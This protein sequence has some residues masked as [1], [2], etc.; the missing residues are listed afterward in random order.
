MSNT[1]TYEFNVG[2]MPNQC[3]DGVHR[4]KHAEYLKT[5]DLL[6]FVRDEENFRLFMGLKVYAF[7]PAFLH[8][9]EPLQE[10]MDKL[11]RQQRQNPLRF[12]A[13]N[14]NEQLE[15]INDDDFSAA[16]MVDPNRVGKTTAAYI[17]A[18]VGRDPLIKADPSWEIFRDH[19]VEYHRFRRPCSMGICSYNIAKLEDPIWSDVI[20]KWTPDSELGKYG[21]TYDG[22]GGK[23]SPSFKD[24]K[25]LIFE[26]SK[27]QIGFYTYEMDQ[28]NYEGAALKKWLWDEQGEEAKFDGADRGTRTTRGF[29]LFSLTP[30]K[31]KGRPD[32][33]GQGWIVK[34]LKG[35]HKKGHNVKTYTSGS[36]RDVPDWIYHEDDKERE[37]EKWE[38]EPT[39]LKQWKVVA[40]GRAR[41]YG[42][43]HESEGRVLDN[44]N[45]EL[46]LIDPLWGDYAPKNYSLYRALDHGERNP[47]ACLWFA[48]DS[49]GRIFVYREYYQMGN[50]IDKDCR[51]IIE[52]SGNDRRELEMWTSSTTGAMFPR[53][54][55]IC[56]R[57]HYVTA[58]RLDS[59]SFARKDQSTGKPHGDLYKWGGLRVMPAS[60]KDSAHWVPMAQFML[61]PVH[62]VPHPITGVSPAPK[63]YVFSTLHNFVREIEGYVWEPHENPNKEVRESPRKVDDHLMSCLQYGIQT[64]LVPRMLVED[65]VVRDSGWMEPHLRR[66]SGGGDGYREIAV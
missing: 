50:V 15:F 7:T 38:R 61:A 6:D 34:M 8:Q 12:Y 52:A 9:H 25:K 24:T 65:E 17:K 23:F 62:D 43:P 11:S 19:G 13:P 49:L 46:H 35:N 59:R 57:E 14:S 29:H 33:G 56:M 3:D 5:G 22:K 21:R 40:E 32:T 37:F 27:S 16:A 18:C 10:L 48:V 41:L 58:A 31:V 28:G 42:E 66:S 47:T 53:Y 63:L 1:F 26:K 2:G 45:K 44:W 54:E 55:E 30:H 64:P 4:M 51:Q 20:K 60:G 36:I 39:R